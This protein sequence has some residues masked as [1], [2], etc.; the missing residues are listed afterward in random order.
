[1]KQK[2]QDAILF[3]K[4]DKKAKFFLIIAVIVG[5]YLYWNS[6]KPRGRKLIRAQPVKPPSSLATKESSE[7]IVNRFSRELEELKRVANFSQNEIE[8]QKKLLKEFDQRTAM[9]FRKMLNRITDNE[10]QLE[11][12]GARTGVDNIGGIVDTS[13]MIPPQ[14]DELPDED[15]VEMTTIGFTDEP[16]PPPPPVKDDR[17]AVI[18]AGDAVRVKLLAGVNAPTNGTPYPVLFE[19]IDDVSGPDGTMLPLGGARLIAAAQGSLVDSRALFRLTSLSITLPNNERREISVDGWMVGEDGIRG[20]PG[21]PIDPIG[22]MLGQA[23]F[24]GL[25]QGF[26]QGIQQSNQT[27]VQNPNGQGSVTSFVNGDTT[28]FAAGRGLT[29]AAQQ[30]QQILNQRFRNLTPI[31]KVRSGREATAIFSQSV[32]V[33]GL[34]QALQT[35]GFEFERLD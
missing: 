24:V 29:N 33:P 20:L 6:A 27:F 4:G 21:I 23:G 15:P 9:I 19:L 16:K 28:N 35:N 14:P 34:L 1:M 10:Q 22:Q 30:W 32:V 11:E 18:G 3:I 31:I 2:I 26:G 12:I 7:D 17:V 5:V 8:E 13:P 25:I